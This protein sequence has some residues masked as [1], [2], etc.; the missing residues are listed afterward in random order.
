MTRPRY[1]KQALLAAALAVATMLVGA[2]AGAT[3]IV[4]GAEDANGFV[5]SLFPGT[6][7]ADGYLVASDGEV[8]FDPFNAGY[9]TSDGIS[10]NNEFSWKQAADSFWTEI[11][12][13]TWVIPASN[14]GPGCGSENEPICEM[15]G[16]FV[17]PF[18]WNTE[19]VALGDYVILSADG[20]IGDIITLSNTEAG[21]EITFAS[22]PIVPEPG[23]MLLVGTGLLGLARLRRRA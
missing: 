15:V 12:D 23:T 11:N 7:F 19:V 17:S 13:F 6:S 9:D 10:L 2:P 21:A 3:T 4:I 1:A 22:D 18:P 5:G 14:T 16:H 20:S 8:F